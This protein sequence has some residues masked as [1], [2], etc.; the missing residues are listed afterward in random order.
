MN[1]LIVAAHPDDEILGVGGTAA[2]HLDHG[3]RVTAVV[4]A[5]CLSASHGGEACLPDEARVAAAVIGYDLRFLGL[6]GMTLAGLPD[7]ERNRPIEAVVQE[8][9]P[10]VVYTHHAGDPHSDHRAVAEAV[11]IATRPIGDGAPRRVLS[12]E[13][14]SSTEWAWAADF[15]AN[16]FVD[17]TATIDRKLDAMACYAAELRPPPHPRNRDAL[18]SRAAYW[19]QVAGCYYAE[20]FMLMREIWR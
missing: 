13:T 20:A 8:I 3:D 4:V 11:M 5:D 15:R 19:G 7:V 14:P 17:V 16:V 18:R 2:R 1:V 9:R 12:F 6:S 10:E